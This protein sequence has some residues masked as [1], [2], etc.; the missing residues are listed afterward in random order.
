[1]RDVTTTL[2][3]PC[4]VCARVRVF[5]QPVCVDEQAHGTDCPEWACTAC[6]AAVLIAPVV[7]LMDRTSPIEL[8]RKPLH[9]GTTAQTRA[10]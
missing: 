4:D 7:L 3:L 1:V 8:R 2:D 10:A 9:R 6:G 5:A